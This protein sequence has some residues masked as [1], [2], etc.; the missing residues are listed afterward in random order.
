MYIKDAT[1]L[2]HEF[3]FQ[4]ADLVITDRI[5]K[6]IPMDSKRDEI[7]EETISFDGDI[8]IPGLVDI[9]THGAL[10]IDSMSENVDLKKWRK[11]MLENGITTFF[12]TTVSSSPDKILQSLERLDDV[13]G[14]YLEGPFLNIEKAG[15]HNVNDITLINDELIEKIAKKVNVIALAP[16]FSENM[17]AIAKLKSKGI[18]ISLGHSTADYETGVK[19]FDEGASLLVH[20]FNAMNPLTHRQPNLV[21]AALENENVF[22]E[23]VSDGVH[24]HPAIVRILFK[25]LGEKRMVL[26]SDSMAAT[27]LEDG[28][29]S[30]GGLNVIVKNG[31]AR[32]EYGAIAGSTKNIMQM[33][34]SAISFGIPFEKGVE[35]ATLTPARAVGIENEVGSIK[36]GKLANLVRLDKDYN[37]KSVIYKGKMQEIL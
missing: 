26:I 12:P 24:L 22:C 18:R 8:L 2:N 19:A 20:T 35:M 23:V 6:I 10:G 36:E 13:D 9:H 25:T 1:I 5:N 17:A 16:E 4:K 33:L 7:E 21:G 15:A 14:I 37:I 11:Y 34:R 28:K 32:T 31:V 30:L 3:K 29:Y 27:G